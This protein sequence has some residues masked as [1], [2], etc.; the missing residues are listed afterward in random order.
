KF[1]RRFQ[2]ENAIQT[3][4]V[5]TSI[6]PIRLIKSDLSNPLQPYHTKTIILYFEDE[7]QI[8]EKYKDSLSLKWKLANENNLRDYKIDVSKI[9]KNVSQTIDNKTYNNL[10]K[11][12]IVMD[13]NAINVQIQFKQF[14]FGEQVRAIGD[15]EDY[16]LKAA[17]NADLGYTFTYKPRF[18]GEDISSKQLDA[19]TSHELIVNYNHA[20]LDFNTIY[21][22]AKYTQKFASNDRDDNDSLIM[23][24]SRDTITNASS[25]RKIT[26]NDLVP[27][28]KYTDLE[29]SIYSDLNTK[30]HGQTITNNIIHN[31]SKYASFSTQAGET[32]AE[33]IETKQ[34]NNKLK[35]KYKITS[36]DQL[37]VPLAKI[38]ASATNDDDKPKFKL[39]LTPK[40][41]YDQGTYSFVSSKVI[42]NS[43]IQTDQNEYIVEFELD[44]VEHSFTWANSTDIEIL[45]KIEEGLEYDSELI[46]DYDLTNKVAN[47]LNIISYPNNTNKKNQ[48]IL[49]KETQSVSAKAFNFTNISWENETDKTK[50]LNDANNEIKVQLTFDRYP[51]ALYNKKLKLIFKDDLNNQIETELVDL[52]YNTISAQSENTR[53]THLFTL[54]TSTLSGLKQNRYY[55]FVNVQDESG[56]ILND[57]QSNNTII[58]QNLQFYIKA[59]TSVSFSADPMFD[60]NGSTLNSTLVKL[61]YTDP[62]EIIQT[63]DS[64]NNNLKITIINEVT[65]QEQVVFGT[66]KP[67]KKIEFNIPNAKVDEGYKIKQIEFIDKPALAVDPIN[68]NDNSN[69]LSGNEASI[70]P[71]DLKITNV[72]KKTEYDVANNISVKYDLDNKRFNDANAKYRALYK[73]INGNYILSNIATKDASGKLNVEIDKSKIKA[74][75]KLT[76]EKIFVGNDNAITNLENQVDYDAVD[77]AKLDLS[78]LNDKELNVDSVNTQAQLKENPTINYNS[79]TFKIKLSSKDEFLNKK[80]TNNQPI[81]VKLTIKSNEDNTLKEVES[82]ITSINNSSKEAEVEFTFNDL[83]DGTTYS[84]EAMEYSFDNSALE[85]LNLIKKPNINALQNLNNQNYSSFTTLDAPFTITKF[86]P[87]LNNNETTEIDHDPNLSDN[88]KI[89]L[90]IS[91][92]RNKW[93]NQTMV[94]KFSYIASDGTKKF[95]KFKANNLMY[96]TSPS[97]LELIYDQSSDK[98]EQNRIY[99]FESLTL[100]T[101]NINIDENGTIEN[102]IGS[103]QIENN[104]KIKA[105][106]NEVITVESMNFI[107]NTTLTQ[108]TIEIVVNDYDDVLNIAANKDL[109]QI[110]LALK[111]D[112]SKTTIIPNQIISLEKLADNKKKIKFSLQNVKLN[113]DYVLK[114]FK[115][116]QTNDINTL[117]KGWENNNYIFFGEENNYNIDAAKEKSTKISVNL[118]SQ[119]ANNFDWTY[120]P[121]LNK[122]NQFGNFKFNKL[123]L[124]SNVL[125]L[126][127]NTSGLSLLVYDFEDLSTSNIVT[128]TVDKKEVKNYIKN[129]GGISPIEISKIFNKDLWNKKLKIKTIYLGTS[130][131]ISQAIANDNFS[132]LLQL[133]IPN[134]EKTINFSESKA[135]NFTITNENTFATKIRNGILTIESHDFN[136]NELINNNSLNKDDFVIKIA[137]VSNLNNQILVPIKSISASTNGYDLSFEFDIDNLATNTEYKITTLELNK[138]NSDLKIFTN[139]NNDTSGGNNIQ[140]FIKPTNSF[141]T[142]EAAT[143]TPL[144]V[145][146]FSFDANN[147]KTLVKVRINDNNRILAN[148]DARFF[149]VTVRPKSGTTNNPAITGKFQVHNLISINNSNTEKELQFFINNSN[150]LGLYEIVKIELKEESKTSGSWVVASNR[151]LDSLVVYERQSA[152]PNFE[153]GYKISMPVVN[154]TQK[155][156]SLSQ[157]Q[158]ELQYTNEGTKNLDITQ[159]YDLHALYNTSRNVIDHR[160]AN[161][162]L[163]TTTFREGRAMPIFSKNIKKRDNGNDV[164]I[165]FNDLDARVTNN[166]VSLVTIKAR[167]KGEDYTS[168]NNNQ[169][170]LTILDAFNTKSNELEFLL[171]VRKEHSLATEVPKIIQWSKQDLTT[172]VS[173]EMLVKVRS[174]DGLFVND[175]NS[176]SFSAQAVIDESNNNV[177]VDAKRISIDSV[178]TD[179]KEITVRILFNDPSKM[180]PYNSIRLSSFKV[181]Y[182][183]NKHR[184]RQDP[185]NINAPYFDDIGTLTMMGQPNKNIKNESIEINKNGHAPIVKTTRVVFA[186]GTRHAKDDGRDIYFNR[187]DKELFP[188]LWEIDIQSPK[189]ENEII[190]ESLKLSKYNN[191]TNG[192]A[193]FTVPLSWKSKNYKVRALVQYSRNDRTVIADKYEYT[194]TVSI[195]KIAEKIRI[196]F[197]PATTRYVKTLVEAKYISIRSFDLLDSNDNVLVEGLNHHIID[198]R[199]IKIQ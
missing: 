170:G 121:A 19:K 91:K 134:V 124:E 195:D 126:N 110:G 144:R 26:L 196:P 191:I 198:W 24:V 29:F 140:K 102:S 53:L 106:N 123:N 133:T 71:T 163:I 62:N 79:A 179:R 95:V 18:N 186:E 4:S 74:N 20:N 142:K 114:Y 182:P 141:R 59:S 94:A 77:L 90:A 127:S 145:E 154:L 70:G 176:L 159:Y 35:V 189:N 32:K 47:D 82:T 118:V 153:F 87:S 151:A 158:M 137:P 105:S 23:S 3:T 10:T 49:I 166:K 96:S 40:T 8:L 125:D 113:E 48:P 116:N 183:V 17:N 165:T 155:Q 7:D 57:L 38:A 160:N 66:I 131:Q 193:L 157:L 147:H 2:L 76:L 63:S 112:S 119:D 161:N 172:D 25:S 34:E 11:I 103:N 15:V 187:F 122:N 185:N 81:K 97:E 130:E 60:K 86:I 129:N 197:N 28:R 143:L 88:L 43:A 5:K 56:A 100:E 108:P 72:E 64:N 31:Y 83:I 69:K 194:S 109:I 101:N 190:R 33:I 16:N 162:Q 14:S 168:A 192:T 39:K 171:N 149:E 41:R 42:E 27:N 6:S 107:Q 180:G 92:I 132:S 146:D 46:L 135:I 84:I 148:T 21:E 78:E 13:N 174:E 85:D 58:N 181:L 138:S 98:L 54:P 1:A 167:P 111:N 36:E 184:H 128:K 45:N 44:I 93:K 164:I 80:L 50:S 152:D 75:N 55:K 178:S 89:K 51:K 73:D 173:V 37:W 188:Q 68:I 177:R 67:N 117:F 12:T 150:L 120:T 156:G 52:T 9:E 136:F 139:I 30:A 22:Q 104:F 99:S 65:N 175:L 199:D 115:L 169:N 61:S